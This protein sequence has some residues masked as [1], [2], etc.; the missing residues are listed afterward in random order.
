MLGFHDQFWGSQMI[1][2]TLHRRQFLAA[3]IAAAALALWGTSASGGVNSEVRI[4][5]RPFA[6]SRTISG[7][8]DELL[9]TDELLHAENKMPLVLRRAIE[10]ELARTD[11]PLDNLAKERCQAEFFA[12]LAVR[13]IA[14]RTLRRAGYETLAAGCE[15]VRDFRPG[16]SSAMAVAQ[17]TIG[18][19][20]SSVSMPRLAHFAYGAS[21]HAS[22]YAFYAGDDE[23]EVALRTGEYCAR[24]LVQPFSWEDADDIETARIW[25]FAVAAINAGTIIETDPQIRDQYVR[26]LGA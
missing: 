19:E 24:A 17:H 13:T 7:F 20:F 9:F 2:S 4:F 18:R 21:A 22:T 16:S 23:I 12:W 14:P 3:G 15:N 10:A 1:Q 6:G 25:G 26:E 8:A 5:P 11:A